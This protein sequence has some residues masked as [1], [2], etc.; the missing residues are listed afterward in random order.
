MVTGSRFLPPRAGEPA[1]RTDGDSD[2]ASRPICLPAVL[3]TAILML[4]SPCRTSSR[5]VWSGA[6]WSSRHGNRPAVWFPC[7]GG[8]AIPRQHAPLM[9]PDGRPLPWLQQPG[10]GP[11]EACRSKPGVVTGPGGRCRLRRS[12]RMPHRAVP[13]WRIKPP[14]RKSRHAHLQPVAHGVHDHRHQSPRTPNREPGLVHQDN[15]RAPGL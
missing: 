1:G 15:G 9:F 8:A 6:I 4:A 3:C 7:S 12:P 10:H 11:F 14:G 5:M 13:C 2:P